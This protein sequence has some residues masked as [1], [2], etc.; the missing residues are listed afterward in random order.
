MLK[1]VGIAWKIHLNV[2]SCVNWSDLAVFLG[3]G[4]GMFAT[5][6]D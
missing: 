6:M 1:S 4:I 3:G 5:A 2:G